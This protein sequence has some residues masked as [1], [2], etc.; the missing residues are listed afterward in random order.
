MVFNVK[1]SSY[2]TLFYYLKKER[3]L[4]FL[5]LFVR[6]LMTTIDVYS[7]LLIKNLIDDTLPNKNL[8]LLLKYSSILIALYILR[9]ILAINSQANGKLMGSKIKKTMREDLV[10]KVLNQPV[11]FFKK[12]KSGDL[13]SRVISDLDSV[14]T[15]C[16]RGLEDFIFSVITITASIIIMFN[17]SF[18]LSFITLLPLPITLFFVYKENRKMKKGYRK[19]RKNAG[20]LSATLHDILKNI[21]FIKDNSLEE[22]CNKK[23]VQSNETLLKSEKENMIPSSSIVSGVTFY[24]NITQLLIIL[25]GGFL[26]IK[27]GLSMGIILSFLLLVDRFRLRIMRM[28]GLVDI[29][30][31]GVSGVT[32]FTE[33]LNLDDPLGGDKSLENGIQTIEFKNI[34]FSYDGVDILKNFNLKINK[35]EKIAIVGESGIGKSTTAALL[36]RALI[37][38]SGEI[39]INN[40]PLNEITFKSY[41]SHLGIVDQNDYILNDSILNNITIIKKDFLEEELNSALSQ[42]FI[43]E[44]IEK[45]P[46]K[47]NT[48]IGE[49]GTYISSGQKQ[50]IALA[51]IFLKNPDL[52][53]LDEA[54]NALDITNEKTILNNIKNSHSDKIILAITH[55]LNILEDFDKIYVL[56][57]ENIVESGSFKELMEKKGK[58]YKLFNGIREEN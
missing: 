39:L 26:Y 49:T 11:N 18:K 46:E 23:F 41:L 24:S 52:I 28:V 29:Y 12:N 47:E 4:L 40:T 22:T 2:S 56:G 3:K 44:M 55:R 8:P 14:S 9:L 5:F 30:Q 51:R 42:A 57:S 6:L 45:L 10:E 32:R 43:Y 13:I 54:T 38:N 1:Y 27:I 7:P 35:G 58:F 37:P 31:K 15:L 16:H 17:F 21:F 20:L 48:I 53:L 25:V 36:K 33:I 50:K 34:Y 19:I